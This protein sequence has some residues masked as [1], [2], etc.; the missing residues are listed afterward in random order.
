MALG[1]SKYLRDFALKINRQV[2]AP[3]DTYSI[4]FLSDTFASIDVNASNPQL[5][6]YTETSGGNISKTALSNFTITRLNEV[7]TFDADDPATFASNAS[8]PTDC[9]TILIINDTSPNDDAWQAVD[10]TTDGTTPIDLVNNDLSIQFN[11]SGIMTI[12][13]T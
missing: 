5:S 3:T 13:L 10:A 11:A 12:T 2:Y 1:D 9:R 4:V 8:N 7:I 6:S